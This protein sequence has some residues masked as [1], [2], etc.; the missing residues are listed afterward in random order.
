MCQAPVDAP[1][2]HAL[3][4]EHGITGHA[5]AILRAVWSGRGAGV[6][7]ERIFDAM[8]AD[9]PEGGP[10]ITTMYRHLWAGLAE[11]AHDLE[12]SGVGIYH[13]GQSAGGL[14]KLKVQCMT[15]DRDLIELG[16]K[17][18]EAYAT[19]QAMT[20]AIPERVSIDTEAAAID[21][22]V[23]PARSLALQIADMSATTDEGHA[24]KAK[25]HAFL[26]GQVSDGNQ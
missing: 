20:D 24:V 14:F 1:G 17:F 5:A 22:V 25:A 21:A 7:A 15:D 13:T 6:K 3:I 11:L 23:Q 12:G 19:Y 16:R 26:A 2:L 8:Y 10:A 9:D 4:A 18:D